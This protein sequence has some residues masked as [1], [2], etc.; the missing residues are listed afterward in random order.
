MSGTI[1][2]PREKVWLQSVSPRSLGSRGEEAD[3]RKQGSGTSGKRSRRVQGSD[4]TEAEYTTTTNDRMCE[5]IIFRD[6][7]S[8]AKYK[9]G[10]FVLISSAAE[11]ILG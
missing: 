1:G 2:Q 4:A 8:F 7:F 5:V 11:L 6:V 3:A 9:F 10:Y